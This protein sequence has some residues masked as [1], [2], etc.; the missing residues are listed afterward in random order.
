MDHGGFS[1]QPYCSVSRDNPLGT[2]LV[3]KNDSLLPRGF[4]LLSKPNAGYFPRCRRGVELPTTL[5]Q[6]ET[7]NGSCRLERVVYRFVVTPP[8]LS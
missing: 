1:R 2:A 3:L 4:H 7:I 8:W 6:R 5:N